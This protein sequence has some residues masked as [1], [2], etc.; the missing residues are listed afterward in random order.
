MANEPSIEQMNEAIAA[1][2]GLTKH[3]D[4]NY[5]Y[6]HFK[7]N[8]MRFIGY[9][10]N[11]GYDTDWNELMRVCHLIRE[12]ALEL[13]DNERSKFLYARLSAQ[14]MYGTISDVHLKAYDYITW[15]NQQKQNN[16]K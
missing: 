4:D 14:L 13:K 7:D 6:P 11:L 15:F 1:F 8:K 16:D 10:H 5:G 3:D 9:A 2:E 12:K